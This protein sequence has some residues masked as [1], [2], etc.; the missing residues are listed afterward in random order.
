MRIISSGRAIHSPEFYKKKQKAKRIKFALFIL[1]ILAFLTG[2]VFFLRWQK[3][4]ITEVEI[5]DIIVV[6]REDMAAAV[7]QE[8]SGYYF[9]VIPKNNALIYRRGHIKEALLQEFPRFKSLSLNLEGFKKLAIIADE[10][11]P[12]ALY[13]LETDNC[14]FLDENGLIF[15]HAPSFS[16]GVYFI[17]KTAEPMEN[18][19]GQQLLPEHDFKGLAKFFNTTLPDLN[20]HVSSF[21]IGSDDYRLV[22]NSGG[23]IIWKRYVDLALIYSNL[24]AF[25]LDEAIKSQKDFMEKIEHLDLR[26]ENKVFYKFK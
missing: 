4:L 9:F 2:I 26:T 10:R 24:E 15:A 18:P 7:N 14:F 5:A 19:M 23:K 21:E 22:L 1:G 20:V 3:F 25:L 6:D 13:C 8:L 16:D 11:K 17:Y 12:S